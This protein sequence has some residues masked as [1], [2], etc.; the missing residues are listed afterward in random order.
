LHNIVLIGMTGSGKTTVGRRISK[1]YGMDFFD[2]DEAIQQKTGLTPQDLV[3]QRGRDAF[4]TVQKEILT[5]LNP[6]H[7]VIS[8]GGGVVE[9]VLNVQKLQSI[10]ILFYLEVDFSI[11][12]MRL[13]PTRPLSGQNHASFYELYEKRKESYLRYANYTCVCAKKTV[14][15][16][17]TWIVKK[18]EE[19]KNNENPI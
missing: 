4:L 11:L 10:G 13:D 17:A 7:T 16:M 5:T 14:D 2:T 12:Q 15:E 8:T 1:K 9:D 3:L 6:T 18:Y 19:V